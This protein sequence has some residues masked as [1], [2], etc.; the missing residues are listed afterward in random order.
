MKLFLA[1]AALFVFAHNASAVERSVLTPSNESRSSG[2]RLIESRSAES[3]LSETRRSNFQIDRNVLAANFAG[4]AKGNPN[5]YFDVGGISEY[6]A[7]SFSYRSSSKAEPRKSANGQV[8]TVDRNLATVGVSFQVFNQARKSLL[9][10][11]YLL[12]GS[13]KDALGTT[14][15]NGI[16]ARILG[17]VE[18][19][20]RTLLQAGFDSNNMESEF[21]GDIYLGLG[22]SI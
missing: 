10:S 17:Q 20:P 3:R 8:L 5:I 13:E 4:L 7:P 9:V 16:G 6:V 21:K 19:N 18:L 12:F 1:A 14:S 11:P 15:A 2:T 22:L